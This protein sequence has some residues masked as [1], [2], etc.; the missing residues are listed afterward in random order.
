[1]T[2]TKSASRLIRGRKDE[3]TRFDTKRV[4]EHRSFPSAEF[5]A[6]G[7]CLV[8][9]LI[10]TPYA[11]AGITLGMLNHGYDLTQT[12]PANQMFTFGTS[13]VHWQG[14]VGSPS[15]VTMV[16]N[17][18]ITTVRIHSWSVWKE[19]EY[20]KGKYNW[21]WID[22][23]VGNLLAQNITVYLETPSLDPQG[24]PTWAGD[25][26]TNSTQ[27]TDRLLAFAQIM[28][29]R[30]AGKVSYW[31][32]GNEI[33]WA[34]QKYAWLTTNLM[35]YYFT[36]VYRLVR[37]TDPNAITVINS[38]QGTSRVADFFRGLTS[39]GITFDMIGIDPYVA[40]SAETG[41]DSSPETYLRLNIE[42]VL[43][44]GKSILITEIGTYW[45]KSHPVDFE[46]DMMRRSFAVARQYAQVVGLFWYPYET[47]MYSP[48]YWFGLS[49]PTQKTTTPVYDAYKQ[50]IERYYPT[51]QPVRRT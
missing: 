36:S 41:W 39:R 30:Y 37:Q 38:A 20:E 21:K 26:S 23:A 45:G 6:V 8:A 43:P 14:K 50:I 49:D 7:I 5:V 34:K 15:D 42:A 18:G 44:F 1:M 13:F 51:L 32:M 40:T 22:Y 2:G 48:W 24:I 19:V 35:D 16:K 9:I 33:D 29:A 46:V 27:V 3:R 28:I 17:L 10:T 11:S 12:I 4:R 47:M 25:I 31:Q